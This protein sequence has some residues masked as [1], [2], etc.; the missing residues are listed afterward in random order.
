MTRIAYLDCP[1]GIAGDMLLAA[2]L[3]AGADLE[4]I[5]FVGDTTEV[6]DGRARRVA[7][8]PAHDMDLLAARIQTDPTLRPASAPGADRPDQGAPDE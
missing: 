6:L 3:D 7:F 4:R 2:L 1:S 8:D 5:A